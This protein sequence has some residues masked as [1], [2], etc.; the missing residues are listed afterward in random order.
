MPGCA[1]EIHA[2]GKCHKHYRQELALA[3]RTNLCACGCGG[4]TEFEFVW[5]HHTRLFSKEEQQRRGKH[6]NGDTQRDPPGATS[7]RKVLGR[8]EHRRVAEKMLGRPLL[9]GEIVHHKDGNRRNNTPENLE[10]MTQAEHAAKHAKERREKN[11]K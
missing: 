4:L 10:V 1:V 9:Q 5:G 8:H 6:N 2:R 7:Y 3:R 11:A